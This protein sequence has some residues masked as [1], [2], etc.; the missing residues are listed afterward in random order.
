MASERYFYRFWR[1]RV[2]YGLTDPKELERWAKKAM[3]A[4]KPG[5]KAIIAALLAEGDRLDKRIKE[6]TGEELT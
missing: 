4:E 1:F 2:Q 5:E 3:E 6:L